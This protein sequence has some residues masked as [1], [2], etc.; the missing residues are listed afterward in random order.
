MLR[1]TMT[2]G[3]I[4]RRFVVLSKI[5]V[6]RALSR[7]LR[8]AGRYVHLVF[9]LGNLL[10][11]RIHRLLCLPLIQLQTFRARP[12]SLLPPSSSSS[13]FSFLFSL[14]WRWVGWWRRFA[15]THLLQWYISSTAEAHHKSIECILVKLK[16]FLTF[17]SMPLKLLPASCF[18]R[19]LHKVLRVFAWMSAN[20]G[21]L[22]LFESFM[23]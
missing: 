5:F 12:V 3:G 7:F 2:I 16:T 4:K 20:F 9:L 13:F 11:P 10:L 6:Q 19:S 18:S 21:F 23:I 15:R 17:S 14:F 1:M 8:G 22:H